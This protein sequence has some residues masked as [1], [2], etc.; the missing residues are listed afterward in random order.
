[1]VCSHDDGRILILYRIY[2]KPCILTCSCE[3]NQGGHKA[4]ESLDPII[5]YLVDP[6]SGLKLLIT[7]FLNAVMRYE[8]YQQSGTLP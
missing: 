1:M 2:N 8:A 7:E 3:T 6:N 5:N 4:M